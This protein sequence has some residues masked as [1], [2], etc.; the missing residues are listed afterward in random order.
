MGRQYPSKYPR[1]ISMKLNELEAFANDTPLLFKEW[2][3]KNSWHLRCAN[4]GSDLEKVKFIRYWY[5]K[6]KDRERNEKRIFA[7]NL[8]YKLDI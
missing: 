2:I 3:E 4:R 5:A 7:D 8:Q 6:V 1:E